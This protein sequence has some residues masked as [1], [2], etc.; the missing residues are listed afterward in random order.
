MKI[1]GFPLCTRPWRFSEFGAL[2]LTA[3]LNLQ[4]LDLFAGE[5]EPGVGRR[6]SGINRGLQE[7]FLQITELQFM[8]QT[9]AYVQAKFFPSSQRGSDSE[10]EQPARATIQ[11]R[12]RP[13]CSPGIAC[14]QI[15]EVACEICDCGYGPIHVRVAEDR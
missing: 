15:L 6:N 11:A 1:P 3:L 5:A 12:P 7:R 9:T 2:T 8:H 14:D 13:D 4:L 10:R